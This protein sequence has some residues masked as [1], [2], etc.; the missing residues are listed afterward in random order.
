MP[1]MP[2]FSL[3]GDSEAARWESTNVSRI[4]IWGKLAVF[5]PNL[6]RTR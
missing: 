4:Y 3:R 2:G 5:F 6:A 1:T